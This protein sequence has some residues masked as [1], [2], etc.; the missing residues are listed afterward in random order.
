MALN[1]VSLKASL[2]GYL[3]LVANRTDATTDTLNQHADI[4]RKVNGVVEGVETKQDSITSSKVLSDEGKSQAV[5]ELATATASKLGFVERVVRQLDDDL[6][7]TEATL[8]TIKAPATLGADP[9]LRFLFGKEIRDRYQGL[10][11]NEKDSAF[12]QA[13]QAGL[14]GDLVLWAIQE[15]PGGPAITKEILVNALEERARHQNPETFAQ[16]AQ[17]TLLHDSLSGL[18]DTVVDWLKGL[19]GDPKKI[20]DELGGPVPPEPSIDVAR[21]MVNA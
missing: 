15:T 20:F 14:D 19:G 4:V 17:V 21:R 8:F 11:Q 3:Q 5:A 12:V 18:R 13:T 16:L 2:S 1:T 6:R 7:A 9:L 10:T